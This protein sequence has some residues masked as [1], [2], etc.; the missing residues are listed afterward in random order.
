[1]GAREKYLQFER[2]ERNAFINRHYSYPQASK[3]LTNLEEI[4]FSGVKKHTRL[5]LRE[6]IELFL[7]EHKADTIYLPEAA[8]KFCYDDST[9]NTIEARL[10]LYKA[11]LEHIPEYAKDV[12]EAYRTFVYN[13]SMVRFLKRF[14]CAQ[15][16]K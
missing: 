10:K 6:G 5:G 14:K 13:D 11:R 7:R 1:M 15:K 12:C 3:I 16:S 4:D 9:Q 2:K 8:R